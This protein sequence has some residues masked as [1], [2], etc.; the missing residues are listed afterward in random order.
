MGAMRRKERH[1]STE[2]EQYPSNH[3]TNCRF[4]PRGNS[5]DSL[6]DSGVSGPFDVQEVV[7]SRQAR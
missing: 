3:W 1:Y 7:V 6:G 2:V 5:Q 4:E